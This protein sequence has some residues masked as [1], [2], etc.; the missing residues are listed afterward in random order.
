MP[1]PQ[2]KYISDNTPNSISNNK[3]L[4]YIPPILYI[5]SIYKEGFGENR[6]NFVI[7]LEE[8]ILLYSFLT[9]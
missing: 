9:F 8:I 5:F 6:S 3:I 7:I 1:V 2:T 4:S